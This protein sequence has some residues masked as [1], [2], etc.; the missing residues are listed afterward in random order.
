MGEP[1]HGGPPQVARKESKMRGED[2]LRGAHYITTK[3][4]DQRIDFL[5][6]EED[7]DAEDSD[8]LA[9]LVKLE[10]MLSEGQMLILDSKMADYAQELCEDMHGK[11]AC[12]SWPFTHI[13]WPAA[14]EALEADMTTYQFCGDTYYSSGH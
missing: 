7:L 3:E 8:E 11:D 12:D 6:N 5:Q 10:D 4:I 2:T 9:D 13:D 1:L 14:A